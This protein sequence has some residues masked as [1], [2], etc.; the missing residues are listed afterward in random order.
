[1][2]YD[3]VY[4]VFSSY[5]KFRIYFF[6]ADHIGCG[7]L[8]LILENA[9]GWVEPKPRYT[10][11]PSLYGGPCNVNRGYWPGYWLDGLN[12]CNMLLML[13]ISLDG[14]HRIEH[15]KNKSN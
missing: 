6:I 14:T 4:Y 11:Y 3:T 7:C 9:N 8:L 10:E 2:W 15:G 1:M 5:P 12:D 13:L